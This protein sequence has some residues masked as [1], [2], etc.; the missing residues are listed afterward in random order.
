MRNEGLTG[1]SLFVK[2]DKPSGANPEEF[3]EKICSNKPLDKRESE[4]GNSGTCSL[5][6]ED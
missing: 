3:Y 1:K 6:L 5:N 4:T 2:V